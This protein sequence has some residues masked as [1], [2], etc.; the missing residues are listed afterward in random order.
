MGADDRR[1]RPRETPAI[2]VEHRQGP[3]I[4]CVFLHRGGQ[5][6]ALSKEIR[7]TV[8]RND[9][10]GIARGARGVVDRN[11]VP[12]VLGHQPFEFRIT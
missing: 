10:F 12:F 1:E 5:G 9:T 2:A 11:G 6:V 8:M 4:D 3:Q 7:A